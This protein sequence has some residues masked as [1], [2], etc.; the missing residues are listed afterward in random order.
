MQISNKSWMLHGW[1]VHVNPEIFKSPEAVRRLVRPR[2]GDPHVYTCLQPNW[3]KTTHRQSWSGEL[4]LG[5]R[6][7]EQK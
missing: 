7:V 1:P 6:R 5:C 4:K 3:Q 2:F